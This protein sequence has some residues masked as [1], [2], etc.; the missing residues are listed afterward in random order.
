MNGTKGR[1]LL[2]VSEEPDH[3][4]GAELWDIP[5]AKSLLFNVTYIC[6]SISLQ[7]HQ[8]T[9]LLPATMAITMFLQ[10]QVHVCFFRFKD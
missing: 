7:Q 3:M 4:C 2:R 6:L 9:S 5:L 10:K 8:H 1:V